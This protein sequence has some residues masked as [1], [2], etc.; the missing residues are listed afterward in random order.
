MASGT[1]QISVPAVARPRPRPA[2]PATSRYVDR[3]GSVPEET[4]VEG[5]PVL[6]LIGVA[7]LGWVALM[8]V[9]AVLAVY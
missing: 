1:F 8:T 3:H 5:A 9:V 7:L 4:P 6:R 2:R